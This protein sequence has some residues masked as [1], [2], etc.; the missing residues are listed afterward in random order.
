M[1][2]YMYMY[3]YTYMC[4]SDDSNY[5][6]LRCIHDIGSYLHCAVTVKL[7]CQRWGG[8]LSKI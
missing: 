8:N 3:M 2:M 6:D 1:Y 4:V 7:D 5:L